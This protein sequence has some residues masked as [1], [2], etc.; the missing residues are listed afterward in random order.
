MMNV[1]PRDAL[2]NAF[3]PSTRSSQRS[4]RRAAPASEI[5]EPQNAERAG[6]TEPFIMLSHS[7]HHAGGAEAVSNIESES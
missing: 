6:R 2:N 5:F 4:I 7:G 1:D 3:D